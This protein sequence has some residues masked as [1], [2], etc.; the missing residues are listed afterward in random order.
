MKFPDSSESRRAGMKAFRAAAL[1]G[2]V[3]A[4]RSME[5]TGLL[6]TGRKAREC[7]KQ[8]QRDAIAIIRAAQTKHG[9]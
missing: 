9:E 6:A 7:D 2:H 1:K 8:F 5:E 4:L 3:S